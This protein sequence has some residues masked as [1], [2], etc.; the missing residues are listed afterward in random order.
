[1]ILTPN[2]IALTAVE[3]KRRT[4]ERLAR[5]GFSTNNDVMLRTGSQFATRREVIDMLHSF[6]ASKRQEGEQ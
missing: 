2:K 4:T 5:A 3:Q 6:G 1:M